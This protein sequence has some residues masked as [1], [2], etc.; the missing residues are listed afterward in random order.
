MDKYKT[1]KE[2]LHNLKVMMNDKDYD[3]LYIKFLRYDKYGDRVE[4]KF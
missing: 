4:L 1:K 2:A 3:K